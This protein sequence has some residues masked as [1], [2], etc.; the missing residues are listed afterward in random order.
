MNQNT[1]ERRK[2]EKP[3]TVQIHATQRGHTL[4]EVMVSIS[5]LGFMIVALY[6]GFSSGFA[7]LRV[8]RE[9]LRAT[10]ILAERM[11]V[12]RLIR[13]QDA[14]PGFIP[15]T[16]SAPFYATDSTNTT[17]GQFAYEGTVAITQAPITESYAEHLRSIQIKLTWVSGRV[18]RTREM[19]TF[20]S[21]FGLQ[22]YVY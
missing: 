14:E 1:Q 10:Q 16:F 12:I 18:T 5:V 8:A 4:V 9:N 11:E 2:I 22:N 7:V 20:V 15:T 3:K 21:K 13:W 17:T 19:S 6:A